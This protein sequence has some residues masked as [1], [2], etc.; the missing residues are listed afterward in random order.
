VYKRQGL[1]WLAPPAPIGGVALAAPA[2]GAVITSIALTR[3]PPFA[4]TGRNLLISVTGFGV[5]TILFG[6]SRS[7]WLSLGALALAGAF[8]M[9]SVV[10]R[11]LMLQI[12]TPEALLGRVS[13]V[14]QIFIGSSNEI[15]SFESGLTARWWGAVPAVVVGGVATLVVVATVAW[16]VPSLRRLKQLVK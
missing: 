1:G 5:C 6:L 8:D 13:S 4:H 16:R 11:S 2:V 15:G 3:W 12:R 14:N 10:I 9:I 7:L